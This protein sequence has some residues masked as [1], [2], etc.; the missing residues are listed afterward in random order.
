MDEKIIEYV[1]ADVT[2]GINVPMALDKVFIPEGNVVAMGVVIA[3]DTESRILNLSVLQNNSEIIR[4]ADVRF[5]TKTSGGT[6]KDSLRPVSFQGGRSFDVKVAA[7]S[8]ST[9]KVVVIQVLFMVEKPRT[10]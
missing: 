8:I 7:T 10:Y 1:T 3:G 9:T 4:P 6:F 2:L 5:S